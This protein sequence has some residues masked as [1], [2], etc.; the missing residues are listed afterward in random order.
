MKKL[1]HQQL[2][3]QWLIKSYTKDFCC[4]YCDRITYSTGYSHL[5][6]FEIHH[7]PFITFTIL[8]PGANMEGRLGSGETPRLRAGL[9]SLCRGVVGYVSGF[10]GILRLKPWVSTDKGA[11]GTRL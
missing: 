10:V 6:I 3:L 1:Q 7:N 5:G 8:P 2:V 9:T 11:K 4:Y